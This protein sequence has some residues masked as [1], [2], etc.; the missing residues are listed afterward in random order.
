MTNRELELFEIDSTEIEIAE[1]EAIDSI[2]HG[3]LDDEN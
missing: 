2:Y 1:L 3:I